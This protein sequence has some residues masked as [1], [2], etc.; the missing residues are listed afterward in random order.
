LSEGG[1]S[2]CALKDPLN[3][4]VFE[5]SIGLCNGPTLGLQQSENAF[6]QAL[7]LTKDLNLLAA[8][9]RER[10]VILLFRHAAKSSI[11]RRFFIRFHEKIDTLL[12][13]AFLQMRDEATDVRP[14]NFS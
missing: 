6:A 10:L 8:A 12:A 11:V 14:R 3:Q 1:I 13:L 7:A 5:T 4:D 2:P 9:R